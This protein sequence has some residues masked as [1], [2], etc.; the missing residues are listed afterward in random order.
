MH[1]L[2]YFLRLA[3]WKMS[4][5]LDSW[6]KLRYQMLWL[7]FACKNFIKW[8]TR[9]NLYRKI[10]IFQL[11]K[12]WNILVPLTY[13]LSSTL[14]YKEG[15]EKICFKEEHHIIQCIFVSRDKWLLEI[16]SPNFINKWSK[17]WIWLKNRGSFYRMLSLL[18][19]IGRKWD[20][21]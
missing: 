8:K 1:N 4:L 17:V 6:C 19:K 5:Y 2:E 12:F 15:E 14:F 18:L 11:S 9:I 16:L 21:C 20:L 13:Q 7:S 3:N 10:F